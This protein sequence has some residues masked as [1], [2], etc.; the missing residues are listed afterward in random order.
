VVAVVARVVVA[1]VA[2]VVAPG[3][4]GDRVAALAAAE[5]SP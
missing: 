5:V 4:A 1:V 2:R 3:A